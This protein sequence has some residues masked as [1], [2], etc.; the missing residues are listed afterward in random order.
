MTFPTRK[1]ISNMHFRKFAVLTAPCNNQDKPPPNRMPICTY[2][3][4]Q[5]GLCVI[6]TKQN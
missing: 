2:T 6:I 5:S 1:L 4:A 3:K